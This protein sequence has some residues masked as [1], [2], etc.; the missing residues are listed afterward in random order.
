MV[1]RVTLIGNLGRDPEIRTLETGAMVAKFSVA[2]DEGYRD[3]SG[4]WVDRVEWH[5]VVA[6]RQLADRA[7]AVLKKGM[8]IYVEGKLSTRKWK[9]QNDVER[10]RTEVVANYFRILNSRGLE[11]PG[12]DPAVQ[13][14]AT[15]Q[16][17]QSEGGAFPESTSYEEDLP[18]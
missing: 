17:G 6:W 13:Q 18:F 7:Q 5:E 9:D 10:Y 12:T 15:V 1:N 14:P 11:K 8:L 3:T 16:E 4:N 2:T